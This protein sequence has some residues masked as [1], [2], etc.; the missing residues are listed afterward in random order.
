MRKNSSTQ[1]RKLKQALRRRRLASALLAAMAMPAVPA[2]AQS[3]P[4][5]G[6]VISGDATIG[7]SLTEMVITQ[8]TKGAII[9]WGSFN[10]G[11]GYGVTFDQQFGSSSVTLNRVVGFGYGYGGPSY[12]DG[13]ISANGNVFIINPWGITFGNDSQVNVGG[14]VASTLG[15]TDADF[16]AGL[17]SGQYHFT[18]DGSFSPAYIENNG[19]ITAGDGGLGFVGPMLENRGSM[20]T[21]GGNI[22]FGAATDVT[23]DFDG[24]GLTQVTINLPSAVDAYLLQNMYGT[25]QADAGKI[26]L[27]SAT[28]AGGTGGQIYASGQLVARTL[29]NV[30]GRVELTTNGLAML[31]APGSA[32]DVGSD[33]TTGVIN[34]SSIGPGMGGSVLIQGSQVTFANNEDTTNG[35][36]ASNGSSI[37]ADGLYSGGQIDIISSGNVALMP[38]SVLSANGVSGAGGTIRIQA[39]G[40]LDVNGTITA[41]SK[42]QDGGSVSLEAG[43]GQL[44]VFGDVFASG[45]RNGGQIT[46]TGQ[47]LLFAQASSLNA[48]GG[49]GVGGSI[50]A[51]ALNYFAAFG[52]FSARGNTAGGSILTR[53]GGL[54]DLRGLQVDAGAGS[55]GTAGTWTLDVPQLTVIN[56]SIVGNESAPLYGTSLQDADINRAFY[57]GT[58]V[59][60]GSAADIQFNGAQIQSSSLADLFLQVNAV[61]RIYGSGFTIAGTSGAL[62]MDFNADSAGSRPNAGGIDFTNATLDSMGGDI[63]MFGQSDAVNGAASSAL[64]GISLTGVDLSS[65]GGDVL[66]RG[67]S[68]G[69]GSGGAGVFLDGAV[70]DAG[71]GGIAIYGEGAGLASGVLVDGSVLAV[72]AGGLLIDGYSLNADGLSLAGSDLNVSGGDIDLTGVGADQ[73]VYFA[74]NLYS[75]GGDITVHGEGGSGD[76]TTLLGVID[77][78]GGDI[79][80]FGLSS[81]AMG[82]VLG[83]GSYSG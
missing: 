24:D 3:L 32:S 54:F 30:A 34:L 46:V 77:S 36:P 55:G 58:N 75:G 4:S 48:N 68:T 28:T 72:G 1:N 64:S 20:T 53:S 76:G 7:G 40:N 74:G 52:A 59:I 17:S 18:F 80:L 6:T 41:S 67:Y 65:G 47:D 81:T 21:N 71:A 16:N 31:G 49:S 11:S 9:N 33:Y 15:M 69:S 26:L 19:T 78:A 57:N 23:L 73:G 43:S 51:S 8:T 10:V 2:V 12:I 83:G 29:S 45:P 38:L 25:M 37:I 39:A 60:L 79:D 42:Y 62:D 27:R 35:I 44:Q 56:G 14:L 63:R 50:Q 61:G 66:L 82:M 13:N 22:A 70:L 5:S